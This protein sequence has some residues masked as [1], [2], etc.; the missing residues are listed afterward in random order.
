MKRIIILIALV[1]SGVPVVYA[2]QQTTFIIDKLRQQQTTYVLVGAHRGDWRNEPEN[3][4][5]AMQRCID[6]GLDIVETDLRKT[7]DGH[8]I[9]MHDK[10]L[11]RTTTGTGKVSDHT[12][13]EIRKLYLKNPLGIV[14][15]QRV[16]TLEEMLALTRGKALIFLDKAE[17]YIP[18]LTRVLDAAKMHGEV[19]LFGR[20]QLD[21]AGQLALFGDLVHTTLFVPVLKPGMKDIPAYI[22]DMQEHIRPA[23]YALEFDEQDS[24]VLQYVTTIRNAGAKVWI[25]TLWAS[26]CGGHDDELSVTDPQQGWGWVLAHKTGILLTDRPADLTKYLEQHKRRNRGK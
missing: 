18:E 5:P 7:S 1:L 16:P 13:D 9:I 23:A 4:I 11:D 26:M 20:S 19:I 21:Y 8:L 10:T 25:S 22:A 17:S 15:R 2:Q 24:T 3:S 14:T 12:L 6:L